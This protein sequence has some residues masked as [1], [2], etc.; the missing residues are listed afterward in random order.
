MRDLFIFARR[1][2]SS[3]LLTFIASRLEMAFDAAAASAAD[4]ERADLSV[5]FSTH[6]LFSCIICRFAA[7]SETESA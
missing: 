5:S 6:T 3:A 1:S 7:A 2:V 4:L